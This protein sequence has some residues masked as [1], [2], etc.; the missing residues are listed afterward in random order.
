MH[1]SSDDPTSDFFAAMQDVTP[2]KQDDKVLAGKPSSTLAQQLKRQSLEKIERQGG[3]YLSIEHVNPVDP[4]DVLEYKK[5]GVQ[6]GVFKNLR[7]G[8]YTVDTFLNVQG[9][10]LEQAREQLFEGVID[11]NKSGARTLLIKHGLG[12]HSKPFPALIKSYVNQWLRQMPE[13]IAFH[14]AVK[15]RGGLASV[16]VLLKKSRQDKDANREL[17]RRK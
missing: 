10:N 5:P 2:L 9:M 3:N 16:Y 4:L 7:L 17:H 13:V 12:Q 11:A 14:S 15:Q 6:Q 8:K 1:N